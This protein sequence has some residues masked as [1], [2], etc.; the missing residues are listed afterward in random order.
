MPAFVVVLLLAGCGGGGE[1][2]TKA[3]PE[4][5]N[6]EALAAGGP[7]DDAGAIE[8]LLRD[9]ARA[10]ERGDVAAFAGTA[11][12]DQQARDRRAAQRAARLSLARVRLVPEQLDTA[13]DRSRI[14]VAMSYRVLGMDRPFLTLRRVAARRTSEGWRISSD[15]ARR[16]PLPWEVAPFQA[17]RVPHVVLLTSGSTD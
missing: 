13:G 8:G 11:T 17:T 10:L 16:E 2:A 9:R 14:A 7:P 6:D 15:V 5:G 12:G 1:P 3:P 4:P